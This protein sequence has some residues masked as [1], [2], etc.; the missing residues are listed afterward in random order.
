M[1]LLVGFAT[2]GPT[3]RAVLKVLVEQVLGPF[4]VAVLQPEEDLI[5][6]W[7]GP[8][9]EDHLRT[10]CAQKRDG[11]GIELEM[12][13]GQMDLLIVQV[14]ADIA[15]KY[16]CVDTT[17]LCVHVREQW[18]GLQK[19]FPPDVLIVIPAQSIEAWLVAALHPELAPPHVETLPRPVEVL[20]QDGHLKTEP[21]QRGRLTIRKSSERYERLAL[22]ELQPARIATLRKGMVELDRFV[23]KLEAVRARKA[24]P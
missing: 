24:R 11:V 8:G 1:S 6:R 3:D 5:L 2:E 10:W 14:D 21:D 4:R 7:R 9:G 23:G 20:A 15:A 13:I 16:G 12:Q 18:L 19:P 17:A 22:S